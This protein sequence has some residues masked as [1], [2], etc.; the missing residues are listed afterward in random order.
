[1]DTQSLTFD[2]VLYTMLSHKSLYPFSLKCHK[3]I[4]RERLLY[5]IIHCRAIDMDNYMLNRGA[6]DETGMEN[7]F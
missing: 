3:N 2:Q 4:F 5:A 7:I 1:M 6:D